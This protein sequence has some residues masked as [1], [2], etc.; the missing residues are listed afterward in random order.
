MIPDTEFTLTVRVD[1]ES[2]RREVEEFRL[3]ALRVIEELR[4]AYASLGPAPDVLAGGGPGPGAGP[5]RRV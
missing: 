1:T 4:A 3:Y 2:A 5:N